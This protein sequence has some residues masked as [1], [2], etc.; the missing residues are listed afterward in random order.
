MIP[1]AP[2]TIVLRRSSERNRRSRARLC[3]PSRWKAL[4]RAASRNRRG[5]EV[6]ARA[7]TYLIGCPAAELETIVASGSGLQVA[8]RIDGGAVDPHLEMDVRPR[9]MAR[10]AR[11]R[12]HLTRRDGLTDRGGEHRVVSVCRREPVAVV[13]HD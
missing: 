1:R 4:R 9:R 11:V 7:T 2:V 5:L 8:E 3:P 10:R 6:A 13:D 12:D